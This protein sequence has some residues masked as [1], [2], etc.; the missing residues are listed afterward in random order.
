MRRRHAAAEESVPPGHGRF[1]ARRAGAFWSGAPLT[2]S[3]PARL[4][5]S[6]S[7]TLNSGRRNSRAGGG[8]VGTAGGSLRPRESDAV[9]AGQRHS[10]I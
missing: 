1:L 5:H 6:R 10:A 3:A 9:A 8:G 7:P 2:R 4:Q